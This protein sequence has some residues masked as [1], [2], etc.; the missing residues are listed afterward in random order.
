[1]MPYTL[2][3]SKLLRRMFGYLGWLGLLALVG[4]AAIVVWRLT[5]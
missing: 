1:M 2:E 5:R 4:I 3:E